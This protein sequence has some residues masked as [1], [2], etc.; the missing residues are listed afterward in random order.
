M[1]LPRNLASVY[2]TEG[3]AYIELGG[4][5]EALQS[6]EQAIEAYEQA[7]KAYEQAIETHQESP[8]ST[9]TIAFYRQT[10]KAIRQE[11]AEAYAWKGEA[12]L[13][14][15]SFHKA[16]ETFKD[17]IWLYDEVMLPGTA[18]Y[19]RLMATVYANKG[20]AHLKL[21]H[22]KRAIADCD[23]ALSHDR[24]L[25]RAYSIKIEAL[26]KRR[27]YEEAAEVRRIAHNFR[28]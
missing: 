18:D 21:E 14:R 2:I 20:H 7:M 15:G 9:R 5:N 13:V 27:R 23:E 6:C 10:I 11:Y 28:C 24:E 26:E 8:R 4:G 12:L 16:L 22:S 17:V 1:H 25:C 3:K 19:E